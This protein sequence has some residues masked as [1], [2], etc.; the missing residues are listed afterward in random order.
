MNKN[1][2]RLRANNS[3]LQL[4]EGKKTYERLKLFF[5]APETERTR[6]LGFPRKREIRFPLR[7]MMMPNYT[8]LGHQL[9]RTGPSEKGPTS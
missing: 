6:N 2:I 4:R 9:E 8:D 3:I 1:L 7:V 5:S